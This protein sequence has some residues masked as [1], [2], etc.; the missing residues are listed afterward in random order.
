MS[1]K[2]W[3]F[4]VANNIWMKQLVLISQTHASHRYIYAY[5]MCVSVAVLAGFYMGM[6][7]HLCA[8]T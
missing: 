8:D 7:A 5:N 3:Q 1:S 4:A 2:Y 6:Y